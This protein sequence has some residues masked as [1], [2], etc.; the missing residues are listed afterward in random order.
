MND[1]SFSS[2]AGRWQR[3]TG[4]PTIALLATG[5]ATPH[6]TT[7][8]APNPHI[9]RELHP[10]VLMISKRQSGSSKDER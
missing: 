3:E 6:F 1:V 9:T 7:S 4:D 2:I 8:I 10:V 5:R